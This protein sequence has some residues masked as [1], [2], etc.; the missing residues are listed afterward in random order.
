MYY[1]YLAPGSYMPE[2][3]KVDQSAPS[4]SFGVKVIEKN[5][6]DTPGSFLKI[7]S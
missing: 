2:K 5:Y 4:Y 1:F 7:F 3:V 6:N